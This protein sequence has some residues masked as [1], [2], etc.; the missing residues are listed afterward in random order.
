MKQNKWGNGEI[1]IGHW[2]IDTWLKTSNFELRTSDFFLAPDLRN[3]SCL[4]EFP[5]MPK[6]VAPWNQAIFSREMTADNFHLIRHE[7][8]DLHE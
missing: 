2:F 4:P 6:N 1:V 5:G 8:D 3:F 7:A